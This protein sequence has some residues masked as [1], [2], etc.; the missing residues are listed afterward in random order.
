M[1]TKH[2]VNLESFKSISKELFIQLVTKHNSFE[3]NDII[4]VASVMFDNPWASCKISCEN[5]DIEEYLKKWISKYKNGYDK[6]VSKKV[7]NP[8][9]TKHDTLI[10]T[11]ISS[12]IHVSDSDIKMISS[13][14]RLSMSAENI[15]GALIEEY[16]SVKLHNY[17]WFCCWGETLKSID[18]CNSDGTLLQ[19]KTSNNSENSSSKAIREGTPII[20]WFRRFAKKGTTNWDELNKLIG[21]RSTDLLSEDNFR[22]FVVETIKKNPRALNIESDNYWNSEDNKLF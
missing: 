10:D 16:L 5:I 20:H 14:H 22:E 8:I 7:S 2:K 21:L 11:I 3:N 4:T 6:R 15:G 18:F 9:G 13:A 12:R 17:N 19:V 1:A